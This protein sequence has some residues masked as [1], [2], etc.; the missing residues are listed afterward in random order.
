[1]K[2]IHFLLMFLG[3]LALETLNIDITKK[4]FYSP[5]NTLF[6]IHTHSVCH[7]GRPGP[8]ID[9][10]L[11][12]TLVFFHKTKSKGKTTNDSIL[13]SPQIYNLYLSIKKI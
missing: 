4:H 6:S 13:R 1:M 7:P 11:I 10:H 9:G 5:H 12:P 8:Y 3:E 2:F